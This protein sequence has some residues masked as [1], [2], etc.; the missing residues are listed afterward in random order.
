MLLRDRDRDAQTH[1]QDEYL[2]GRI[3][4]DHAWRT[5][6]NSGI[7]LGEDGARDDPLRRL[8]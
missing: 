5:S 6:F 7:Q 4:L 2:E 8:L 3:L 1:L